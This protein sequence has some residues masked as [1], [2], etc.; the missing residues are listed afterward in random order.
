MKTSLFKGLLLA[1]ICSISFNL[2][3]AQDV[4]G[5]EPAPGSSITPDPS[6][7][8]EFVV[9][10]ITPKVKS[11]SVIFYSDGV[12][13]AVEF[14][15]GGV[16]PQY[17]LLT[18]KNNPTDIRTLNLSAGKAELF[19][20]APGKTYD[21]KASAS[22]GQQ[23]IVGTV[24]T[25][26]YKAGDPVIVSENLYRALSQYV[27][28]ENQT[29]TLS[30]YLKQLSQLS[31]HEKIAFLQQYIMNGATLPG[32]IK[33][34]YPDSQV[35]AAL[36]TR[37]AE[38]ECICNFVM[39]QV[40]VAIPDESGNFDFTI[41]PKI[42]VTPPTFYNPSSYWARG[43]KSQ[44]AAKNQFL[45]SEGQTAG[46]KRRTETWISGG[47]TVSDN[48]VRIGYHLMCVGITELPKE[49]D[50]EKTISYDFGYSTRIEAKSNTGGFG[51][52][53][54]Q[55]AASQAQDWAVAVVTREKV[56][57][58][59]DVQIL[60]SALGTATSKCNGGVPATV[61][62]DIAKIGVSVFQLVK[63]V[64]TAQLNDIVNQTNQI[65]DK[66]E[67]VLVPLTEAKDCNNALIEKPLL[68]GVA[69]ISFRPND[70][71][72]FMIVSGSS[73]AVVGRRCWN[74]S[75]SIKSSFHLAGVVAGGAPNANSPHCCTNYFS[76]WAYASQNGDDNNR[77]NYINYHLALNSP[78]GWQTVNGLP[79]SG[80][81]NIP[82]AI[83]YA[84]GVN[85]PNGQQCAKEIPIFNNPH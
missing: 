26:P 72:S 3:H 2:A 79:N 80:S 31:Q 27:T 42:S 56:N 49:C 19:G 8:N 57:S 16:V 24:S 74:S 82:T 35:K 23:Y 58:V 66:V 9:P 28:N 81:I 30:N 13:A 60:Q 59:N 20:L 11:S 78:G 64:K 25:T 39:N 46:N 44:G 67:D 4:E 10:V 6:L 63:S 50:C 75:A 62:I 22:N 41:G 85:L 5:D 70:P 43:L 29:V 73:L 51:C 45:I 12:S 84:I 37:R 61:L 18:D 36:N 55:E 68:Q 1:F 76:N 7:L 77:K 54:T 32:S 14:E 71:L 48:F 38:G 47:E 40:T 34:Q 52:I 69:N 15:T 21:I 17:A 53:F 65:I 83:G 33:G